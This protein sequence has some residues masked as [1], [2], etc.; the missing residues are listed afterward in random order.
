LEGRVN[1]LEESVSMQT[2]LKEEEVG[3]CPFYGLVVDEYDQS[4]PNGK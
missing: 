2:S 4:V 1:T 3:I